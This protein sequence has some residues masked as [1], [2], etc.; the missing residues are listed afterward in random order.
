MIKV[1]E[2]DGHAPTRRG[3]QAL[4]DLLQ[5]RAGDT[6]LD[7]IFKPDALDWLLT[8][9]GGHVRD[10]MGFV[11]RACNEVNGLP[12]DLKAAKRALKADRRALQHLHPRLLLAEAGSTGTLAR[13]ADR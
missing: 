4:R 12:I 2:R 7:Q 1:K 5:K 3:R 6:P 9:C 8:Y 13:P 11:R 10:L